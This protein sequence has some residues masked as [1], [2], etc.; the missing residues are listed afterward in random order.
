LSPP[1]INKCFNGKMATQ[2][3]VIK[4]AYTKTIFTVN[5]GQTDPRCRP[6]VI[7]FEKKAHAMRMIRL[8][9]NIET[10]QQRLTVEKF[11]YA[12]IVRVC[13]TSG[14]D[15][16]NVGPSGE[17]FHFNLDG[18]ANTEDYRFSLENTFKFVQ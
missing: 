16:V 17:M 2:C 6:S 1:K 9:E 8:I 7:T 15:V 3:F 13:S 10:K 18:F 11:P 14:L 5:N 12:Y 4:R